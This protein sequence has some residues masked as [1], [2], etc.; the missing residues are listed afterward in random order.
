[1]DT[2]SVTFFGRFDVLGDM[3]RFAGEKSKK[4]FLKGIGGKAAPQVN[5]E[6]LSIRTPWVLR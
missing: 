6:R 5:N 4:D 1:V 3:N 2:G